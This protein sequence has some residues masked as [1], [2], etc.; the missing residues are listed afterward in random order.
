MNCSLQNRHDFLRAK[1]RGWQ[2]V[3]NCGVH[4]YERARG[5]RNLRRLASAHPEIATD[6]GIGQPRAEWEVVG[7]VNTTEQGASEFEKLA[8]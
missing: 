5:R 4:R 7:S 6:C 1:I 8:A 2:Q 3:A